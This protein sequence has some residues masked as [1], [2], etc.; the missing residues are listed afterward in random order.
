MTLSQSNLHNIFTIPTEAF[1]KVKT[2]KAPVPSME[3]KPVVNHKSSPRSVEKQ[4]VSRQLLSERV[5][6]ADHLKD[7]SIDRSRAWSW[8]VARYGPRIS[9]EELL[10]LGQVVALALKLPLPREYKRRKV[11]MVLWFDEHYDEVMP[12]IRSNVKVRADEREILFVD[13][14]P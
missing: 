6:L 2:V 5:W 1:E 13:V 7:F 10:S 11:T 3:C 14:E 4:S 8:L 12:F 9:K